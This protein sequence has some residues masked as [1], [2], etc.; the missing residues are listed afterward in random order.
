MLL[1]G[2]VVRTFFIDQAKEANMSD[3]PGV[4]ACRNAVVGLLKSFTDILLEC[5]MTRETNYVKEVMSSRILS[6]L[7]IL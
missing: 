3:E 6:P 2:F 1:E 4:C 5:Y 7:K